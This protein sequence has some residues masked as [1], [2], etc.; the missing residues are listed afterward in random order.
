MRCRGWGRGPGRSMPSILRRPEPYGTVIP[1]QAGSHY[2]D[3]QANNVELDARLRGHDGIGHWAASVGALSERA[4]RRW[5][6]RRRFPPP[7]EPRS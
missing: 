7:N 2:V 5:R 1:A 4:A 3:R 6:I